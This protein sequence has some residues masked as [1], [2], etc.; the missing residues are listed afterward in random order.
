MS[1]KYAKMMPQHNFDYEY[2]PNILIASKPFWITSL[3]VA[4]HRYEELV[5][6]CA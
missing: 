2:E 4:E 6:I 1:Y 3:L 5:I